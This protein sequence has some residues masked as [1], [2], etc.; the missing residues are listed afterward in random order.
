VPKPSARRRFTRILEKYFSNPLMRVAL[1][2]GIAPRT[3]ALLET[4]GHRT[5]RT[6]T[7]PV[8]NGLSGTST[9]WLVAEHGRGSDYVKNL[10]VDPRVRVRVGRRWHSGVASLMP[11]DDGLARR[12]LIDQGNGVLG[13][14]DGLIFRASS[15]DPLTIRI[16]LEP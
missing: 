14:L 6:R 16:D 1:R 7:T 4:T 11:E 8:G 3:F 2:W 9:F 15:K 12:R 13:R 10:L 5:G